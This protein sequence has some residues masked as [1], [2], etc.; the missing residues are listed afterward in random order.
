MKI[1]EVSELYGISLDT[2]RYYERI[3]LLLPALAR[4][5]ECGV[6]LYACG[7]AWC[8]ARGRKGADYLGVLSPQFGQERV[9][10]VDEPLVL[11]IQGGPALVVV[12]RVRHARRAAA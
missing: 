10:G 9:R 12:V 11:L 4:T 3:G 2:L 6:G 5:A 1:A 7:G 8:S